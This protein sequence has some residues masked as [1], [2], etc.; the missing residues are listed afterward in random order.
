MDEIDLQLLAQNPHW[1]NL[2]EAYLTAATVSPVA[3][4]PVPVAGEDQPQVVQE[5]GPRWAA[6]IS[7]F[8]NLAPEAISKMHGQLIAYGWL[9]FQFDESLTEMTYRVSP[10]GRKIL[11]KLNELDL[12]PN[13]QVHETR[14]A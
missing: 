10:D 11:K 4:P 9:H 6:R 1:R 7:Q 3:P 8:A 13:S 14:A 5:S 12:A 2:L